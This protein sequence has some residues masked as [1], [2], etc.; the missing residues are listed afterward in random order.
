MKHKTRVH[1]LYFIG[2]FLQRKVKNRLFLKLDSR[3]AEYFPEYSNYFGRAL[4]LLRSMYDITNSGKLFTDELIEWLV[5]AGI[6]QYQ[7][8]SSIYYKYAPDETKIVVLSYVGDC[9]YWYTSEDI[10]KLFVDTL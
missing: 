4:R 10:G 7:Y 3:Y 2:A 9:I 1:S 8:Q 5:E 6:I